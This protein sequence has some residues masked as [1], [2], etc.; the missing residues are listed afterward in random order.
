MRAPQKVSSSPL[1]RPEEA[2]QGAHPR[3]VQDETEVKV[4]LVVKMD[5]GARWA[6]VQWITKSWT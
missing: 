2:P 4:E 3:L 6:K 5:R 1:M